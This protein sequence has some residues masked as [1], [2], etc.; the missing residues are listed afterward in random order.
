MT[1]RVDFMP[2]AK[3]DIDSLER[4]QQAAVQKAFKRVSKRQYVKLKPHGHKK[5]FCTIA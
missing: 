3:K 4:S 2:E 1:W 5:N